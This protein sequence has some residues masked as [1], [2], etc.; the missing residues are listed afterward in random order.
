M[1]KIPNKPFRFLIASS[2]PHILWALGAFAA[3]SIAEVIGASLPYFLKQIINTATVAL[4]T[5]TPDFTQTEFWVYALIVSIS[6]M[7]IAWRTAGFV[8]MRW[9]T[10]ANATAYKTLFEYLSLHSQSYFSDRF[11]GSLTNKISHASDGSERLADAT[12]WNYYPTLIG[13]IVTGVLIFSAS[14]MVGAVY[15]TLLATLFVVNIFLVRWRRP[16]VVEQANQSSKLRGKAVDIAS[17]IS[18]MWQ[19]ARRSFELDLI[20]EQVDKHRGADIAQWKRSEIG[21][22]V[23]NIIISIAVACMF[24]FMLLSLKSGQTTLGDFVMVVTL[25]FGML[26]TL[27]FIGSM[28][29]GLV[30][31]YGEIEEG[32]NEILI[33]HDL[34]DTHE[35]RELEVSDGVITFDAVNFDYQGNP[36]FSDLNLTI[37]SHQKIGL[38]GASGAGKTTFVSLL[39]R[40][41]DV[42]GGTISVD[43]Q[44]I[45]Q[46]TQDSL[47]QAIAI[48]PQEPTL[49]HRTIMDNIRYGKLDATDE[50]VVCAAKLAQAHEF[51]M[52]APQGYETFVGERGIKLSG[53]QRQRI[54]IAR[55]LLKNAPILILDEATSSLDSESEIYIQKA[56]KELIKNKTVIA[57]AHRLSTLREMD[58]I[59]VLDNGEIA[60]D[61]THDELLKDEG[62]TYARLWNHQ[63][64]GFITDS[65]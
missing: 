18:A 6:V 27:T 45:A 23:N 36:V 40:Q 12:V 65:E 1:K 61:G 63:A 38:I 34:V 55:A 39:L 28:M 29:N 11:A 20:S 64:G 25:L 51:I 59:I 50:E 54:I 16:F 5:A 26:G 15:V 42:V 44:D 46:V 4:S 3:V 60:Q 22:L 21:L 32:L 53:G 9:V 14:T 57:I 2:K 48:I 7:Y 24:F 47:R 13:F 31:V 41:H 52:E 37:S 19:F 58:R 10:G 17:N 49:F 8:G 35:A 56:L 33:P 62:G 30:R 43:G